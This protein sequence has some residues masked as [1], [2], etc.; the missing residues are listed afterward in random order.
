MSIEDSTGDA[1]RPLY[2]VA[3][4]V[5]R[6]RAARRAIDG[7]GGDTLLVGRAEGY[8]VGRPHLAEA[9]AR[10][11]AYSDAGA[12]CLYAPGLRTREDIAAVV[13]SRR[14]EACQSPHRVDD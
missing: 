3:L 8:L 4:A 12:D 6:M 1:S 5:E 13:G 2:D 9:I 10:L 14:A 7:A 11:K